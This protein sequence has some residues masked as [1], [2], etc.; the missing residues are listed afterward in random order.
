MGGW[1]T[2]PKIAIVASPLGNTTAT[3]DRPVPAR[4]KQP[5]ESAAPVTSGRKKTSPAKKAGAPAAA[6]SKKRPARSAAPAVRNGAGQVDLV[7]VVAPAK[8][9]TINKYL[10]PG[11]RVLASDGHVRDLPPKGKQ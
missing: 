10:C 2:R 4:K 1:R 8:A 7:I 3:R 11:Y 9:K 6:V 5:P